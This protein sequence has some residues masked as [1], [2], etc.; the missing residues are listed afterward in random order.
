M[1]MAAGE[2]LE[3]WEQGEALGPLERALI[4]AGAAGA[5]VRALRQRPY[6]R[7][8]AR[9][10]ALR[11]A[12]I[13]PDLVATAGCPGC[14]ARVEFTVP[15]MSLRL[16][17]P[18]GDPASLEAGGYVVDWRPPTPDDLS[19]AASAA[20]PAQ[21]LQR[22]CLVVTADGAP[23]DP[24]VIPADLLDRVEAAMADADPLAEVIVALTCP[25]CATSFESDLD[26]ASFVWTEVE[27]RAR[28]VLHEVDTLARV[29]GWTEPE[30]LALGERRRAAYLRLALDGVP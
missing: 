11:E 20:E 27:A 30:V 7:T 3:L 24:V 4:L 19:E 6:G 15:A 8:N 28:Q 14:S 18:A 23:A 10:L 1:V 9:V 29:Y 25:D 5:D 12:A 13:G 21:A 22:R 2:L 26:V 17:V 16:Q